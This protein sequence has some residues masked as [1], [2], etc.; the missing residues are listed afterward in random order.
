MRRLPFLDAP[1][2]LLLPTRR[3]RARGF[4]LPPLWL[5][6]LRRRPE[7]PRSAR[8]CPL[9]T[10]PSRTRRQSAG[11]EGSWRPPCVTDRGDIVGVCVACGA[12]LE[13]VVSLPGIAH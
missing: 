5:K 6:P 9:T 11:R 7:L 4:G 10:R 3:D 13:C 12:G 8:R 2:L 1:L